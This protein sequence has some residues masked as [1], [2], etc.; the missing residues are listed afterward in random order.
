MEEIIR[1]GRAT[2]REFVRP[3]VRST[4]CRS[5]SL[6][7]TT[8][9]LDRTTRGA[10]QGITVMVEGPNGKR[11]RGANLARRRAGAIGI[12][13]VRNFV[14][15]CLR[16]ANQPKGVLGVFAWECSNRANCSRSASSSECLALCRPSFSSQICGAR[17]GPAAPIY[18][19]QRRFQ[20]QVENSHHLEGGV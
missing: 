7:C 20:Q 15:C 13:L 6:A 9:T 4:A 14:L 8:G 18:G 16:H 19:L 11:R 17:W 12:A 1:R 5:S 2:M 3:T 10:R